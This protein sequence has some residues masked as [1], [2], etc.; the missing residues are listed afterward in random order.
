MFFFRADEQAPD[1]RRIRARINN[2]G[3]VHWEPGGIFLTTC[4]IDIRYFP[5]DEQACPI[6]IGAWA[7][8]TNRMNLTNSTYRIPT[9]QLK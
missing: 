8:H 9:H 2:T 7:Y 4:D 1:F 6:E 3:G 5:F